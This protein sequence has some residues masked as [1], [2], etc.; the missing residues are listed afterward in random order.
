MPDRFILHPD[1]VHLIDIF[2]HDLRSPLL[3]VRGCLKELQHAAATLPG[4]EALSEDFA[5]INDGIRDI[6]ALLSGLLTICRRSRPK[7]TMTDVDM[8][9]LAAEAASAVAR[10]RNAADI[11]IAELPPCRG[12]R[13]LLTEAFTHLLDNAVQAGAPVTVTGARAD[14]VQYIIT[15]QGSGLSKAMK[16][17]AY[18]LFATDGDGDGIGLSLARHILI[19]HRGW[20]RLRDG[21]AGCAA[22]ISLPL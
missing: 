7:L 16:H 18:T 21:P 5:E 10:R 20:L 12:D 17:E 1:S 6:E 22:E 8:N 19:L 2:A 13:A 15:D 3:G 11:T 14:R 4:G 9:A